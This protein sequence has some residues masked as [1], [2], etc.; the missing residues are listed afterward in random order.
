MHLTNVAIRQLQDA[1]FPD[2]VTRPAIDSLVTEARKRLDR[3]GPHD[4]A[5]FAAEMARRAIAEHADAANQQHYELP[6][7]FFRLCL[8]ARLKY[9]CCLYPTGA[10]TLDQA[11]EMALAET[12]EHA[13]LR[14]GQK[15]L[16]MGCGWGSLSLWMAEAYPSSTI[17]AVS[18]SRGQRRHIEA[19]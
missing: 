1:P 17:T 19:E 8:G 4:E 2:F 13:D 12:C 5:A 6:P 11:E 16:E 9:S 14:D 15:I 7:E 18:N 3:D 10:E